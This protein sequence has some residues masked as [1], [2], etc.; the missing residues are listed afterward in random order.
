M[1][2]I[3]PPEPLGVSP[4]FPISRLTK[5]RPLLCGMENWAG[6]VVNVAPTI[7]DQKQMPAIGKKLKAPIW[8]FI[9]MGV[10]GKVIVLGPAPSN[11]T[12]DFIFMGRMEEGVRPPYFLDPSSS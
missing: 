7:I 5:S 1:L 3:I 4:P 9:V 2:G 6:G 12:E 11:P 8:S 10:Q